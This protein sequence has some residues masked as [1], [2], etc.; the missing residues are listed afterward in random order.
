MDAADS[1][2]LASPPKADGYSPP[3]RISLEVEG[4]TY[5]VVATAPEWLVLHDPPTLSPT[6]GVLR[7]DLDGD[8]RS[9]NLDFHDGLRSDRR[10]QPHRRR[11]K[12][13]AEQL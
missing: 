3:L 2:A 4:K 10:R 11:P 13:G 9:E 8:V 6:T 1:A 7:V 5:F 12:A